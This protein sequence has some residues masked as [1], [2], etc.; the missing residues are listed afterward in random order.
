VNIYKHL[1]IKSSDDETRQNRYMKIYSCTDP[2]HTSYDS[3]FS[4]FW[5]QS[6]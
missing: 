3:R 5:Q 4:H 6:I 2:L 1:L